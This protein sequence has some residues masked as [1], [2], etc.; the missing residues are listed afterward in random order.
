MKKNKKQDASAERETDKKRWFIAVDDGVGFGEP[1]TIIAGVLLIPV[2]AILSFVLPGNKT[3]P[4]VDLIAIPFIIE[5][6]IAVTKGNI[7]KNNIKWNN[8]AEFRTLC[9]QLYSTILY[10]C[11]NCSKSFT[12]RGGINSKF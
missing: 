11:S 7:L 4:M 1:A 12:C 6:M 9:K 2:M 3:L 10:E 8:L 5:A